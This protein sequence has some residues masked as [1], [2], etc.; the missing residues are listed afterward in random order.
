MS[1]TIRNMQKYLEKK[2]KITKPKEMKNTQRYFLKLIEEVGEFGL[3]TR[4]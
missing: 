4:Y 2:Y 1:L 3:S